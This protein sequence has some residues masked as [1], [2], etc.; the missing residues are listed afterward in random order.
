VPLRSFD[1]EDIA[2]SAFHSFCARAG[3]N[4]FQRLDNRNE[5]WALLATITARRVLMMK[6][7][8]MRECRGGGDVR[9]ESA[10]LAPGSPDADPRQGLGNVVG[11]A[12]TPEFAA[13]MAEEIELLLEKL[14][15]PTLRLIAVARMEGWSNAEIAERLGLTDRTVRRKLKVI[16]MKWEQEL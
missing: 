10:F 3:E 7:H 16:A 12:P 9:G 15:D 8:M 5:L 11:E 2:L 6:R 13:Q 1:E 4:G 14:N